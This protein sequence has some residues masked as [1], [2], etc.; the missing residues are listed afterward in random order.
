LVRNIN[1]INSNINLFD[2]DYHRT[3]LR[4]KNPEKGRGRGE[5]EERGEWTLSFALTG[6]IAHVETIRAPNNNIHGA[7]QGE[8]AKRGITITSPV[9]IG[10]KGNGSLREGEKGDTPFGSF[11]P[12]GVVD[13]W[14]K[15]WRNTT[16]KQQKTEGCRSGE[17]SG[18]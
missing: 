16:E 11:V 14:F 3:A 4:R 5:V 6:G 7:L 2:N 17:K 13:I 1:N 15:T 12:E 9:C 10:H 18:R 8:R